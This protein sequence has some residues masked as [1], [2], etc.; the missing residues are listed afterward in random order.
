[1]TIVVSMAER[2]EQVA[3]LYEL[4]LPGELVQQEEISEGNCRLITTREEAV[5][6]T[7]AARKRFEDLLE[8]W[9]DGAFMVAPDE[10]AKWW[11]LAK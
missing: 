7:M 8:T 2:Y 6:A 10:R 9:S 3:R 1:M 11:P 4:N 5:E